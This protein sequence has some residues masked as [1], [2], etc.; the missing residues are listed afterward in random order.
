[1]PSLERHNLEY[2]DKRIENIIEVISGMII[3]KNEFLVVEIHSKERVDEDEDDYQQENIN[4]LPDR[5]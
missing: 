2:C 3:L 5:S 4:K 1:M